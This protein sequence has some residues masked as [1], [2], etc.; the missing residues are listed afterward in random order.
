MSVTLLCP[1]FFPSADSETGQSCRKDGATMK[2]KEKY[3]EDAEARLRELEGEIERVRGKAES[4]GQ[5]EQ[6]EYEI[7]REALEKG[8]ED[9]RMRICALKENADTPWEKIRGEIENI[10]SELKHSITMAI[11]RK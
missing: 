11:E 5:G 9:L 10:W 2:E 6:R 8:Y 3:R 7:R 1:C 4:G